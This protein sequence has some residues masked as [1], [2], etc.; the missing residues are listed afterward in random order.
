MVQEGFDPAYGAR[1]L[2]R[3]TRTQIFC[4][5]FFLERQE[6]ELFVRDDIDCKCHLTPGRLSLDGLRTGKKD[7][8]FHCF[9]DLC[10]RRILSPSTCSISQRNCRM[11]RKQRLQ[12]LQRPVIIFLLPISLETGKMFKLVQTII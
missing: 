6:G 11:R 2:R 7:F 9:K 1:P 8:K 12:R 4:R 10:P 5:F 3:V